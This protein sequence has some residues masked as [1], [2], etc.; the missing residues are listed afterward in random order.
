MAPKILAKF[1]DED[2][3]STSLC[4][5]LHYIDT[6][7]PTVSGSVVWPTVF[8]SGD[9]TGTTNQENT[10]LPGIQF[11]LS[12]VLHGEQYIELFA[13]FPPDGT[14]LRS[15]MRVAD[16]LDKGTNAFFSSFF[17]DH[18]RR[19][20]TRSFPFNSLAS[21][22]EARGRLWRATSAAGP[23]AGRGVGGQNAIGPTLYRLGSNDLNPLH[24][25]ANFAKMAG[26]QRPILHGLC[27][28]GHFVPTHPASVWPRV[29]TKFAVR[30]SARQVEEHRR[31]GDFR[32]IKRPVLP[33]N[34]IML[35][36]TYIT[37]EGEF[38]LEGRRR[39]LRYCRFR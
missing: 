26:F 3:M 6:V 22:K 11:D 14:Q 29:G 8:T 4:L 24:I 28:I 39:R 7:W 19:S 9:G 10:D 5:P 20:P 30:Q 33:P 2:I 12:R 13:P 16:V 35:G 1:N 32:H 27:T 15:E 34:T 25:D 36:P 31:R 38:L 37:G 18:F 23:R 21:F 17:C